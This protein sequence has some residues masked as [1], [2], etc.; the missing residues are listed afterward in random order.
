M[1]RQQQRRRQERRA[2]QRQQ[3]PAGK[4]GRSRPAPSGR[5]PIGPWSI[6]AGIGVFLLAAAALVYASKQGTSPAATPTPLAQT[7]AKS[8]DGIQ[9]GTMEQLAYHIHQH[10]T[11]YDHG[12]RVAVPSEIGIPGGE[13]NATCYYW[14][15]VHASTPGIIHVES[16]IRKT[17]HL[18]N[19]LDIWE[20]TKSDANPSGDAYVKRLRAAA[21]QGQ[22]HAFYN[23]KP[24]H[25]SYRSIP[26]TSH[27]VITVEIGGPVVPPRPFTN[28]QGL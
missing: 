5:R 6:A 7:V 15:H 21:A 20:A 22:A 9:C 24:W 4:S 23:G 1:G 17:F 19:F 14:I 8:V 28:W 3:T 2:R 27:A 13:L 11:L 26:L 16:A 18:G 25:G 12:K 10:L